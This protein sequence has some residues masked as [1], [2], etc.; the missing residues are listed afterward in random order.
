[1]SSQQRNYTLQPSTSNRAILPASSIQPAVLDN[2]L[3]R[4]ENSCT[5]TW[6]DLNQEHSGQK[7]DVVKKSRRP[8]N[9][10]TDA[11]K[12]MLIK[13]RKEGRDWNKMK[14]E[15]P[16]RTEHA[17]RA[18]HKKH[19]L[20]LMTGEEKTTK[21][22][23]EVGVEQGEGTEPDRIEEGVCYEEKAQTPI[24]LGYGYSFEGPN[25]GQFNQQYTAISYDREIS[26]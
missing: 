26:G 1:M 25:E 15:L 14:K 4:P 24:P 23:E 11:E 7:T 5:Q 8:Q 13:L 6:A 18:Y 12:D 3:G 21:P 20:G 17:V 22:S 10:W 9:A 19:K 2:E 16:N